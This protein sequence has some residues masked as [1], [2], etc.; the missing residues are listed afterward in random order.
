MKTVGGIVES[1][2]WN[3]YNRGGCTF[4]HEGPLSE[5]PLVTP[6]DCLKLYAETGGYVEGPVEMRSAW[7]YAQIGPRIYFAR[8]G[9][10]LKTSQYLQPLVNL[11]IERSRQRPERRKDPDPDSGQAGG[12][13]Q[14][15]RGL[16]SKAVNQPIA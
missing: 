15:V 1:N 11:I 2:F 3:D 5:S 7:K 14:I 6:R 16:S 4:K 10:V 9:D 13:G 12:A 8:G